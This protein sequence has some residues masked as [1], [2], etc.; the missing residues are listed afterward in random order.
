[1]TVRS[2]E[3]FKINVLKAFLFKKNI[4]HASVSQNIALD[5]KMNVL[6]RTAS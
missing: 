3:T 4:A 6:L 5:A 1:M 2:A